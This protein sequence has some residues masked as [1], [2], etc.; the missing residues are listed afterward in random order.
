MAR[1]LFASIPV[2]AHTANPLP[3]AARLVERGHDV[4]WYAGAAFHDRIAAT[5]ARPVRYEQAHDF[6]G[7]DIFDHFP[8]YGGRGGPKVIGEVF[9]EI[10]VGHAPD[11]IADLRRILKEQPADVML[12]DLLMYGVG[13]LSDLGGPPW[14]TFGDG[15][16]PFPEA[17]TP[18]FGPGLLPRKGRLGRL[19]NRAVGAAAARLIFRDAQRV[20][21]DI[22]TGLTLPPGDVFDAAPSP[23]LHL[24]ASTPSFEYPRAALP[25]HVHWIGALR[26]DAERWTPPA[27]WH[28]V[29]T[30]ARPVVH[31]SQGSLR[32][33]MTEL[34][35]PALKALAA[36]DVL[37]VVTSGA[38]SAA[39]VE[40]AYGGR[41][42]AN[43]RVTR[44][45]PYDELLPHAAVFVTNGGWSG[46]TTALHHGT[47]IV[48]AGMTE[49]KAENGARVQW[50]GVGLRLRT[51]RPSE[52]ALR[53]AVRR[54][55]HEPVFRSAAG[56]VRAE[57]VT[58]DAAREAADLLEELSLTGK[59]VTVSSERVKGN[60]SL[61]D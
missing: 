50:S 2:P 20:H 11:R 8:Q 49:E 42:P 36:Q 6:S 35:V 40:A 17:D 56:R 37:V 57:M 7:G 10:F 59:P 46:L 29:T 55:L 18:P 43:V 52:G 1:F 4:V 23:Y 44:Y 22:R 12:C 60:S 58:H 13:M 24:Q 14:A 31:V 27:W 21:D 38:A 15:P 39:D 28:E 9:A 19:R 16:L 34:V 61:A 47:P 51:T 30:S 25:G 53:D 48:Q 45:I 5:G 33:D 32:S 26:P 54:V 3:I 41:L